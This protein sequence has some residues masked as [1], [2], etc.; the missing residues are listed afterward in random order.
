MKKVILISLLVLLFAC[1][2]EET[3]QTDELKSLA[4]TE[5]VGTMPDYFDGT[6]TVKVVSSSQAT[7]TV[8]SAVVTLNYTF[9]TTLKTGTFNSEGYTFTFEIKGNT[10]VITDPY[11]DMYSFTRTK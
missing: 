11:S 3:K 4:N 6:V 10:L 9:N 7:F 8:N 2:K 1:E 5:W